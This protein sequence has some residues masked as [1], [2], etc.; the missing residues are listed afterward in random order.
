ML[1]RSGIFGPGAVFPKTQ[2]ERKKTE[3]EGENEETLEVGDRSLAGGSG[4]IL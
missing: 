4:E 1:T 3:L 2:V